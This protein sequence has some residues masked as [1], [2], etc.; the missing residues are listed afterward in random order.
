[1]FFV[2]NV[3]ARQVVLGDKIINFL[4]GFRRE[5]IPPHIELDY[6]RVCRQRALQGRRI[7]LLNLIGANVQLLDVLIV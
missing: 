2:G 7:G 1:M 3:F 4:F 6:A 5:P